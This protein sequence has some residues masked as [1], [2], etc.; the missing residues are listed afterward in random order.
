MVIPVAAVGIGHVDPRSRRRQFLRGQETRAARGEID[1]VPIQPPIEAEPG[2]LPVEVVRAVAEHPRA[3]VF[4]FPVDL[5]PQRD[6]PRSVPARQ[7]GVRRRDDLAVVVEPVGPAPR[8]VG[9]PGR[10]VHRARP[11]VP[12]VV[13]HD[14]PV[15]DVERVV[16]DGPGGARGRHVGQ[17]CDLFRGQGPA[18]DPDLIQ[19]AAGEGPHRIVLVVRRA[20]DQIRRRVVGQRIVV[21]RRPRQHAVHVHAHDRLRERRRHVVPFAQ[22]HWPG[23][24]QPRLG[25]VGHHEPQAAGRIDLQGVVLVVR[26][27]RVALERQRRHLRRQRIE[28]HPRGDRHVRRHQRRAR[29][30]A[31]VVVGTVERRGQA[32]RAVR[33]QTGVHEGAVI[34]LAAQIGRDRSRIAVERV[35]Q[36][37]AGVDIR[38]GQPRPAQHQG[39]DRRCSLEN[40]HLAPRLV[41]YC[42]L[43]ANSTYL[44]C[45]RRGNVFE[46]KSH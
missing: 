17:R 38:K 31:H 8:S 4:V 33:P 20:E 35:V 32:A 11:A 22:R 9:H 26:A 3:A 28:P 40:I 7:P 14:R 39:P 46:E 34:A 23:G 37:Q 18:V 43:F 44:H 42:H 27:A 25:P 21:V 30:H 16:R 6:A 10:P 5:H 24:I 2:E 13:H 15:V 12:A 41:D 36:D 1:P 19:R 45:R 29:G